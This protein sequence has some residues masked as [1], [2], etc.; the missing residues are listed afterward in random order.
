MREV[1]GELDAWGD[2]Y[3]NRHLGYR[4]LELVIVR[5][6]PEVGVKSV[7]DL[8]RERIGDVV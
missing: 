1:E 3:L 6:V 2:R 8:L 4:M 7:S 5:V